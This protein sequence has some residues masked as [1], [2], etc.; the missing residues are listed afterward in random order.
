MAALILAS[1]LFLISTGLYL[2]TIKGSESIVF[3]NTVPIY[4]GPDYPHISIVMSALNEADYIEAALQSVLNLDY[5][6]YEIIVVNDRS[7]DQTGEILN[8]MAAKYDQLKVIHIQQLPAG[9]LGKSHAMWQASKQTTGDYL[10]FTDAD[11]NFDP[12][13]LKRAMS[14]VCQYQLDH[15]TIYF[16]Y[17]AKGIWFNALNVDFITES[18]KVAQPWK[19]KDPKAENTVGIGAFNLFKREAYLQSGGL[20]KIKMSVADDFMLA[21]LLKINGFRQDCLYGGDMLT[22]DSYQTVWD[23]IKGYQKNLFAAF[24][25]NVGT[26]MLFTVVH[27]LLVI[28]PMLAL[29]VTHGLVWAIYLGLVLIRYGVMQWVA[30]R[31]DMQPRWAFLTFFTPFISLYMVWYSTFVILKNQG[32]T[33]RDTFYPLSELKTGQKIT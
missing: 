20:E 31:H 9:W 10:L 16:S 33:W 12:D 22:I 29:F 2:L 27:L 32:L 18:F 26:V 4:Q 30:L 6:S 1:I 3:I 7:V 23:L 13:M 19:A 28:W 24:N 15:L 8:V 17:L 14:Y 25:Y 5:P 11:V 21:K